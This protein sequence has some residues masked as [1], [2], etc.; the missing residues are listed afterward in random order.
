MKAVIVG[1]TLSLLPL[2]AFAEPPPP[3]IAGDW[4]GKIEVAPDTSLAVIFHVGET[5]TADSPDQGALGLPGKL[6]KVGDKWVMTFSEQGA[7]F[8]GKIAADGKLVGNLTQNGQVMPT[9][10]ARGGPAAK[11]TP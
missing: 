11:P 5:L 3:E 9:T 10:V 6:E 8:E 7:V 4:T 1:L 2:A